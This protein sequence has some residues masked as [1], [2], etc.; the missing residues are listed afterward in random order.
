MRFD[1]CFL[2]FEKVGKFGLTD[3]KLRDR[4]FMVVDQKN[5]F[6]TGR[7]EPRL[8]LI[9]VGVVPSTNKVQFF[10]FGQAGKL[11]VDIPSKSCP[12]GVVHT[13]VGSKI[14]SMIITFRLG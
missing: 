2:L 10:A 11:V 5:R 12:S 1:F 8:V 6:I 4:A 3:G 13:E 7:Q 14:L 9:K